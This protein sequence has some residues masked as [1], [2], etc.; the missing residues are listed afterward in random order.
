MISEFISVPADYPD[1][2]RLLRH[3]WNERVS[4]LAEQMVMPGRLNLPESRAIDFFAHLILHRLDDL[5]LINWRS[6]GVT[7][8]LERSSTKDHRMGLV[9]LTYVTSGQIRISSG[10]HDVTIDHDM[11]AVIDCEIPWKFT[12]ADRTRAQTLVIPL[13]ALDEVSHEKF[14]SFAV[15]DSSLPEV[16]LL[17]SQFGG[18][19]ETL[20]DLTPRTMMRARNSL[21]HLARAVIDAATPAEGSPLTVLRARADQYIERHLLEASLGPSDIA[22]AIGVS[23]RTI[24]RIFNLSGESVMAYVRRRRLHHARNELLAESNPTISSIATRWL[25]SDA[26]HFTRVFRQHFGMPPNRYRD[27]AMRD[28]RAGADERLTA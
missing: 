24:H 21:L 22:D 7:G 23:V 17:T 4:G 2:T 13:Q 15:V 26:S 6:D 16:R 25:F 14:D 10:D 11:V 8:A 1:R 3:L 28:S 19:A 5:F 27:E 20:D 12:V 18:L 9:A